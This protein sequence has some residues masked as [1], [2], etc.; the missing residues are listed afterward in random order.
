MGLYGNTASDTVDSPN[1]TQT[2]NSNSEHNRMYLIVL[3]QGQSV[4]GVIRKIVLVLVLVFNSGDGW[5]TVAF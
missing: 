5:G 1:K 4:R 2:M 3:A